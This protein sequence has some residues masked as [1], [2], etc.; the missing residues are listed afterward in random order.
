MDV[1]S[2]KASGPTESSGAQTAPHG[3]VSLEARMSAFR[4]SMSVI[5]YWLSRGRRGYLTC[6]LAYSRSENA[7]RRGQLLG[8]SRLCS[9][10]L[11][12]GAPAGRRGVRQDQQCPLHVTSVIT[13]VL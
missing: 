12:T 7:L 6:R 9:Q 2:A 3:W 10:P 13:P 5:G 11:E 4:M 1:V 8:I